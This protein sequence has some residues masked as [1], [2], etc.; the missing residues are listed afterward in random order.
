[1]YYKQT[2]LHVCEIRT[3]RL[4]SLPD[5][6][7]GGGLPCGK[8]VR[9]LACLLSAFLVCSIIGCVPGFTIGSRCYKMSTLT[10]N[11]KYW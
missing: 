2:S 1:M 3:I 8:P 4:S 6:E 5:E 9:P 7:V 11:C 10:E